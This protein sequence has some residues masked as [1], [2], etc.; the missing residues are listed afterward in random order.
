M[1]GASSTELAPP[2]KADSDELKLE[3][4]T[5]PSAPFIDAGTVR[6]PAPVAGS[7]DWPTTPESEGA[8][9]GSARSVGA[10]AT[11]FR[12][13]CAHVTKVVVRPCIVV[14]AGPAVSSHTMRDVGSGGTRSEYSG[15]TPSNTDEGAVAEMTMS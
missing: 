7:S 9:P 6:V 10:P 11:G 14:G 2:R 5:S 8:L 13:N 12:E 4:R 3:T 1:F 15:P